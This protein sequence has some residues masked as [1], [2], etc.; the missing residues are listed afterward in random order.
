MMKA[1]TVAPRG[2][3]LFYCNKFR[4]RREQRP[5]AE[6]LKKHLPF[7]RIA[8]HS[9]PWDLPSCRALSIYIEGCVTNIFSCHLAFVLHLLF[10]LHVF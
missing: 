2:I 3:N 10:S 8:N 6:G 4:Q 9:E 7:A 5:L 1:P